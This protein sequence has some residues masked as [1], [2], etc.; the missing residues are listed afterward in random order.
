LNRFTHE[1]LM[2]EIDRFKTQPGTEPTPENRRIVEDLTG[3]RYEHLWGKSAQ[4]QRIKRMQ[5]APDPGAA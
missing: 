5:A 2:S 3:W 1:V 4:T